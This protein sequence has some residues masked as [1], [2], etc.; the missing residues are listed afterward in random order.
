[1]VRISRQE[2][3]TS[4]DGG[5]LAW[6][7]ART[8]ELRALLRDNE[9]VQ[10]RELNTVGGLDW[11]VYQTP[12][13][14]F[15][16]E[17]PI[18]DDH[19]VVRTL[20]PQGHFKLVDSPVARK[21]PSA[22]DRFLNV[23]HDTHTP[24]GIV[25][26]RYRT[27]QNHE[28]PS[29]LDELVAAGRA[30]YVAAG[31]LRGGAQVWWVAKL[32]ET[33]SGDRRDELDTYVLLMNAHDGSI[34]TTVSVLSV[35]AETETTIAW[36]LQSTARTLTLRHTPASATQALNARRVFELARSYR[37]ELDRVVAQMRRTLVTEKQVAAFLDALLPTPAARIRNDRVINQRGITMA[38]NAKALITLAHIRDEAVV[39]EH[40]TLFGLLLACQVYSDH[41]SINRTTP[42]LTPDEN[43]FKRL[44]SEANLG[45]RA[46]KRALRL[47]P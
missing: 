13:Y 28:A 32:C 17:R 30:E 43:R 33:D 35:H 14:M 42:E 2:R 26:G 37:T 6:S 24:L 4:G 39:P 18:V 34:S 40:G 36:P 19:G 8:P 47:V 31:A 16:G 12:L 10:A 9:A 20:P 45:S 7:Y 27:I 1:M 15:I 44:T 3:E 25:K 5:R 46:F 23:R 29:V 21:R 41:L 11:H 22:P 38:E